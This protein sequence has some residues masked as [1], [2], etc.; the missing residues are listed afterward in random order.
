MAIDWTWLIIG[1]LVGVFFG[2]TIR[3]AF[4]GLKAKATG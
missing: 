2:S 3:G 4:S 1:L